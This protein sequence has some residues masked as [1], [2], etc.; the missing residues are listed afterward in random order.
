MKSVGNAIVLKRWSR[1]ILTSHSSPDVESP[2]SHNPEGF[3]PAP[4]EADLARVG[5][6]YALNS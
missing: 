3:S 1:P 5:F 4:F 6:F 2:F